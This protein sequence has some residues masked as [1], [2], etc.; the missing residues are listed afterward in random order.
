[1][2][3][4]TDGDRR[5]PVSTAARAPIAEYSRAVMKTCYWVALYRKFS[6]GAVHGSD[7]I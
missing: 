6:S 7:Y 2:K 4:V 1:M 3:A 5:P